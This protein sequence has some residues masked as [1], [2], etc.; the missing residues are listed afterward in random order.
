MPSLG[1]LSGSS[2]DE[3]GNLIAEALITVRAGWGGNDPLAELFL[4]PAG[5]QPASNPFSTTDGTFNLYVAPGQVRI[6][7]LG[8]AGLRVQ[9]WTV[10]PLPDDVARNFESISDLAASTYAPA[11]GSVVTAGGMKFERRAG[12]EDV[13]GLPGW[14]PFG[15]NVPAEQFG[16]Q[17]GVILDPIAREI[18]DDLIDNSNA[19]SVQ[20]AYLLHYT[21][22]RF[23][24]A[25]VWD[26]VTWSNDAGV[27]NF[28]PTGLTV[29]APAGHKTRDGLV[30][31][32]IADRYYQALSGIDTLS[33]PVTTADLDAAEA[34]DP[35]ANSAALAAWVAWISGG[36]AV[37]VMHPRTYPISLPVRIRDTV[38]IKGVPG[39]TC[40]RM[41]SGVSADAEQIKRPVV[42][43]GDRDEPA[44]NIHVWGVIADYNWRR[45]PAN[46]ENIEG[47]DGPTTP[48]FAPL[49]GNAWAIGYTRDSSFRW[50]QGFDAYKHCIDISAGDTYRSGTPYDLPAQSQM[51]ENVLIADGLFEGARDDCVTMHAVRGV[52]VVRTKAGINRGGFTPTNVNAFEPDDAVIDITLHDCSGYFAFCGLEAKGHSDALPARGVTVT[53]TF[54]AYGTNNGAVIRHIGFGRNQNVGAERVLYVESVSGDFEAGDTLTGGTS[55]ATAT[56]VEWYPDAGAFALGEVEDG[57]FQAGE[58]VTGPD[59]S[60]V[61]VGADAEWEAPEGEDDQDPTVPQLVPTHPDAR[62]VYIEHLRHVSPTIWRDTQ[63]RVGIRAYAYDNVSVGRF[64]AVQGDGASDHY[65]TTQTSRGVVSLLW[66]VGLV[67]FGSVSFEGFA[68]VGRGIRVTGSARGPIFVGRFDSQNGPK[69]RAVLHTSP[70]ARLTIGSY[71]IRRDDTESGS[72][73]ISSTFPLIASV[74]QGHIE[75]YER[76][77]LVARNKLP[78]YSE[79]DDLDDLRTDGPSQKYEFFQVRDPVPANSPQGTV[80][81]GLHISRSRTSAQQLM[82]NS[83]S[84]TEWSRRY[85]SGA[86][87]DWERRDMQSVGLG[88]SAVGLNS[89]DNIDT[90]EANGFYAWGS[91]PP[92]GSTGTIGHMIH[93]QRVSGSRAQIVFRS[94]LGIVQHRNY[95]GGAWQPWQELSSTIPPGPFAD[96]AAAAS[97]GVPVGAMY[98]QTGG[99]V[100]WRQS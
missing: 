78:I 12:A 49:N 90:L 72:I 6:E 24:R 61:A 87:T 73:A 54:E 96:D 38:T 97:G 10:Q 60:A 52:K 40:L 36:R 57:P 44:R 76:G 99:A 2:R 79:G 23:L 25:G 27:I 48:V 92:T 42:W 5:T 58:T 13:P 46:N 29:T 86:W 35:D 67:T 15:R 28:A 100:L 22:L 34:I 3:A 56:I 69:D 65:E 70:L 17:S 84:G 51:S 59:G 95:T 71:D 74:G 91:S 4:D 75:G 50:C 64:D 68:D 16:A 89:D 1:I 11:D 9:R 62:D 98:R 39:M 88:G 85:T 83:A 43:T 77:T 31:D 32:W 20:Y 47:G 14:V 19:V 94:A 8:A 55:G 53:G 30:Y 37:G 7:G 26:G 66:D 63:T 80:L 33:D 82:W 45:I 93:I 18:V 21:V 41:D 81:W